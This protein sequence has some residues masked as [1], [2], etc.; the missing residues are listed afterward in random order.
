MEKAAAVETKELSVRGEVEF[1]NGE[2]ATE[3][4]DGDDEQ[5]QIDAMK[6][7]MTKLGNHLVNLAQTMPDKMEGLSKTI[8]AVT[9]GHKKDDDDVN[10]AIAKGSK[11]GDFDGDR[12]LL[13]DSAMTEGTEGTEGGEE[14][15]EEEDNAEDMFA[16]MVGR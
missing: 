7:S 8:E 6:G 13:N 3:D 1:K 10:E 11:A 2:E 14:E 12:S 4:N 5:A 9:D 16:S 15:S